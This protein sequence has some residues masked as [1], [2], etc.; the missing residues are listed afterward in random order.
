MEIQITDVQNEAPLRRLRAAI[1]LTVAKAVGVPI[2]I[3][4]DF[5][6]ATPGQIGS[7]CSAST[8]P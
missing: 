4:D 5:R 1:V 3:R 2:R 8:E 6:G 7:Q